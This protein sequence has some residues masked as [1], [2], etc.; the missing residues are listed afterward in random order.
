MKGYVF[1]PSRLAC[2]PDE[3]R[4]QGYAVVGQLLRDYLGHGG[5]VA[6]VR[7]RVRHDP[8]FGAA[9]QEIR[10]HVGPPTDG[11]GRTGRSRR[12]AR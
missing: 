8:R 11:D 10:D 4:R 5:I 12:G 1:D 2:T 9:I 3:Q 7:E 6:E